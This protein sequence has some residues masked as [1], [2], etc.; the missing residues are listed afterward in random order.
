MSLQ[1]CHVRDL[2]A[3]TSRKMTDRGLEAPATIARTGI[4]V[5]AARELGL[6]KS[7]GI[8]GNARIRLMRPRDEVFAPAAMA[9]FERDAITDDHPAEPV[10]PATWGDVAVG[11][12]HDIACSGETLT[13]NLIVRD[14]DA[15][16]AI[17][18]DGKSEMSC[19]YSFDLDMTPGQA[20][21][22]SEY[23]GIMRNIRGNHVAIVNYARGG[24]ALRIADRDTNRSKEG[25]PM[26]LVKIVLDGITLELEQTQAS[27]VE[28]ID[29]DAKAAAKTAQDAATADKARADAADKALADEKAKTA[30]LVEDHAKALAESKAKEVT[31]AQIEALAAE[32]SQ[33]CADALVLVPDFDTKG[34]T[35]AAIRADVLAAVIAADA[36][37]KPIVL[38]ILGKDKD[39]K[40]I[41]PGKAS[42]ADAKKAFDAI[43]AQRPEVV[44]GSILDPEVARALAADN[45]GRRPANGAGS[46]PISGIELLK[47]RE[48]HGG[49]DP[50]KARA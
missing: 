35:V 30:K 50:N 29:R 39:G 38:A 27:L 23:D 11:D 42:E 46:K 18:D 44:D 25:V 6:D 36:T 26:A 49:K 22:G 10:T 17:C 4:Q 20:A 5:Y 43:V 19:G 40:E 12:V 37:V 15:I 2:F 24:S 3:L 7:K 34:K 41:E 45:G 33:V 48:S 9:S 13:A 16:K 47:Y 1:R 31:P 28:K 32:R 14:Q 8:D 21:D